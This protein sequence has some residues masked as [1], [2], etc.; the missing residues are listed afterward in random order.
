MSRCILV[1]SSLLSALA[2]NAAA[3][4]LSVDANAARHP[5]S[6]LIY[7][8][9]EWPG[10]NNGQWTDSG[11]S[12]AMRVGV[13]RWGGN[14]ATSYNWQND[15]KNNDN[16]WYF[17]TYVVGDGTTSTF[18][19]F[20][21]QNLR[22]GTVSLGTVPVMDWTPK[23]PPVTPVLGVALSCSY[24]VSKYGH[25]AQEDPYRT[26]G[27][28][29][30]G[31]GVY[32]TGPNAGKRIANDPSDVYQ[33]MTPAFAGQWVQAILSK[34]GAADLGGVQ[35][36]SLDN[37]PEWWDS[38]HV[39]IYPKA[40]TYDDMM[41]RNIDTAAAVKAADPTALITGPV[42]AGWPGMLF[43]KADFYNGW[44]VSPFQYW[45]NPLDRNAH[46]GVDWTP[47]Y[48]QQMQK[49][50][51]DHGVR[52]LDYLDVHAYI[53]P[54][55]LSES[56]GNTAMETLR[57]T[58]TRALWD[59]NYLLP[60]TGNGCNDYNAICDATGTQIPPMLVRRLQQWIR[61]NYPGTK[62]AI[63]EYDWGALD[64][65][66]GAVAQAD[67]LGIFGREGLDLGTV[68]PAIN[69]TPATP[70]GLAFK[71]FTN[72]DGVGNQ[73]GETSVQ[74]ASDNPDTLSIFAAQRSDTALTI[75]VLN[76]TSAPIADTVALN[77]FTPAGSVQV[78]QYSS[79]NLNA[80][81][82]LNDLSAASGSISATFPAYSMTLFVVPASQSMM[83]VPKP[84]ITWI[85]S[86]SSYDDSAIAPGEIVAIRGVSLGP[87]ENI[88]T[89]LDP[90]GK[91]TASLGGVRVLFNG[92]PAA[93]IYTV[94]IDAN[95]GQVAAIVPYEIAGNPATTTVNV[96]VEYQ[97]NRSDPFPMHVTASLPGLFTDDYSGQGQAASYDQDGDVFT[98][99]GALS[100]NSDPPRKPAT[101]GS[102]IVLFATGEGQ[103]NPPGVDGRRAFGPYP[104]P[105]LACSV[106]VGGIDV[107]PDY[108]GATPQ[109]TAGE[110][111]VNVK[112]PMNVPTGDA[113]PIQLTVGSATSPAG[114]TIA[115][116]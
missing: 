59:P 71:L 103:T 12:E 7:G 101:R 38:T 94:P 8:I 80:I 17:S 61:D 27:G 79:A 1:F 102:Y 9:N 57:L 67:I 58:S 49:Y 41:K 20:H 56:A 48:L 3:P 25:Q 4:A 50:E 106:K 60:I 5:I 88:Q 44:S 78:W 55:A 68:W 104:K 24:S 115:I 112:L 65:I 46:G 32:A 114:P 45:D 14:N 99:N 92:W 52:L 64:S 110:L 43:S 105:V 77:S 93:L 100:P 13:R 82:H 84:A 51:Q 70:G 23:T 47:Y 36:W 62:T 97:G 73:F 19:I 2:L 33:P 30:C 111:Q 21:E 54:E 66:T 35:I 83:S 109:Y 29:I 95:S 81:Q 116:Q 90:L 91:L 40:A 53:R 39:D 108:C 26:V 75:L 34:Y 37:E 98:R 16:D 69:L 72:Y 22:S 31:N 6:P 86:A 96:Q 113:V 107:V 28:E 10:Y 42:Q 76:K 11:M 15:M 85:K 18:N 89:Q 63:T 74:A 87:A